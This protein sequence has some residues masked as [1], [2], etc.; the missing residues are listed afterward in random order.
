[1]PQTTIELPSPAD[2]GNVTVT[3][4][5]TNLLQ[6]GTTVTAGG[7]TGGVPLGNVE[8]YSIVVRNLG[9]ENITV[10]LWLAAGSNAG[11]QV[12]QTQ[13]VPA[14]TGVWT[15]QFS[16]NSAKALAL[17]A[18]TGSSTS[19]ARADFAGAVYP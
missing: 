12:Q 1:M 9:E 4:A 14:N 11:L 16:G 10:S 13:E 8:G 3:T 7:L 18:V 19:T 5:Q 2:E 15:Y 6:P 17:T